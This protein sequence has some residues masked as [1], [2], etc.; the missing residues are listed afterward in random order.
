MNE[1]R[2]ITE[3][4][5]TD[6]AT[7]KGWQLPD[8]VRVVARLVEDPYQEHPSKAGDVYNTDVDEADY[9]NPTHGSCMYCR[10]WMRKQAEGADAGRWATVKDGRVK[11]PARDGA[12][13]DVHVLGESVSIRMW[14]AD[15]WAFGIV[16]VVVTDED[17]FTWGRDTLSG[18]EYGNYPYQV[19]RETG[20]VSCRNVDP[21]N[22]PHHPVPDMIDAALNAVADAPNPPVIVAPAAAEEGS[23]S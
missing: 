2:V 22:D 15:E 5:V 7:A 9:K 18:V 19:D 11:C 6:R 14:K 3:V 8:G 4:D 17:G 1:P 16:E 13:V 21:L 20:A 23:Q 10:E 12:D